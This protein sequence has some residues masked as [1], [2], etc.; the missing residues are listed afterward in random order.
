MLWYHRDLDLIA[1]G[2]NVEVDRLVS[3]AFSP[4]SSYPCFSIYLLAS[5]PELQFVV[6]FQMATS[7]TV[8]RKSSHNLFHLHPPKA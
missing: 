2:Q 1:I 5:D 3:T 4:S 6:G 8:G 7:L